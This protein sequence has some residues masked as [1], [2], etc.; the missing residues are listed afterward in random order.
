MTI[1]PAIIPKD[2]EDLEGHLLLVKDVVRTVQIDICDGRLTPLPSWP[3]IGG[4]FEFK[5]IIAQQR[6]LPLWESFDFEID[7]MVLNPAKE[8]EQWIDA[9]AARIIF[10]YIG[11]EA[12]VLKDC[13]QKTKERGAEAGLALHLSDPIEVVEDFKELIDSVQLMGIQNIGFQGEPFDERVLEQVRSIKKKY[14][15]LPIS[16][17]GS[18]NADTAPLLAEAGADRLVIGSALFK[19]I[20]IEESIGYFESLN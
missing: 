12:A 9:G 19:D 15:G 11:N 1:L 3:Y 6:G 18:V 20:D 5:E 14:P 13:M 16:V 10:H 17:D 8:Y 7:L 4:D 2:F